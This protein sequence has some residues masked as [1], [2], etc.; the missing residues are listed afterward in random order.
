MIARGF[1]SFYSSSFCPFW[2]AF[3]FLPSFPV[4][5][6]R[7]IMPN[8]AIRN[9]SRSFSEWLQWCPIAFWMVLGGFLLLQIPTVKSSIT[10]RGAY[11]TLASFNHN[12]VRLWPKRRITP[13]HRDGVRRWWNKISR[14]TSFVTFPSCKILLNNCMLCDI[15]K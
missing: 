4:G 6:M 3:Q 2:K 8:I 11:P 1:L 15:I 5:M 9:H 10:C 12:L 13:I 14:D 7:S